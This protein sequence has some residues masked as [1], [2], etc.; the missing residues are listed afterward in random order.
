MITDSPVYAEVA[1]PQTNVDESAG[2]ANRNREPMVTGSAL[3]DL[4]RERR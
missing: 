4:D 2:A 3:L 1:D